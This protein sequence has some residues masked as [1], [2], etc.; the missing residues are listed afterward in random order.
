MGEPERIDEVEVASREEV[1]A[2]VRDALS[3]L[4]VSR[5]ELEEQARQGRFTSE[6]ARL[7]WSA[8][9]EVASPA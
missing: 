7:L 9:R 2:A 1:Q 8:I 6:R 5:H 3:R 4:H